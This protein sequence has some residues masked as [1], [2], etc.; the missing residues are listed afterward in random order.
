MSAGATL[1]TH[2]GNGAHAVLPRHPNYI[3]EQLADDRLAASFIVDGFHLPPSFLKVAL[4]AKGLERS[5]SGHRRRHAGRLLARAVSG[6]A[7]STSSCMPTAASGCR[8]E[9]GWPAQLYEWTA[10]STT[11]CGPAG[12]TLRDAVTLATR[13]PARI[14]RIAVPPARP[15][16]RRT[17]RLGALPLRRSGQPDHDSGNLSERHASLPAITWRTHSC[18]PCSHSCEHFLQRR[19]SRRVST[20]HARVRAP[21]LFRIRIQDATYFKFR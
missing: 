2:L 19:V 5:H 17:C 21:Q 15:Q 7:K 13:N 20:R 1:S 11:S 8:A 6:S 12:L 18:V 16:P 4:R 10:P 3:W 9:R 14:G